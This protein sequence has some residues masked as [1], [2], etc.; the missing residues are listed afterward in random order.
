M[1]RLRTTKSNLSYESFTAKIQTAYENLQEAH[2]REAFAL[3]EMI[4]AR[5]AE[6]ILK[7]R[8]AAQV[9]RELRLPEAVPSLAGQRPP[10]EVLR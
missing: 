5:V 9:R 3:L 4:D 6:E 10:Q 2:A 1:A 8:T 7:E